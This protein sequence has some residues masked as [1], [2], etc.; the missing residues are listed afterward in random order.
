MVK[1]AHFPRKGILWNLYGF[2]KTHFWGVFM[3]SS[4]L[5]AA[6]M[7]IAGYSFTTPP[8]ER[9]GWLLLGLCC[10]LSACWTTLFSILMLLFYAGSGATTGDDATPTI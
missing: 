5:G 6:G 9:A 7:I 2:T 4:V 3:V 10:L 8:S 1:P